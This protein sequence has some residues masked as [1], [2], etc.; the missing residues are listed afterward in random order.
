MAYHWY[1]IREIISKG[2]I[3]VPFPCGTSTNHHT[4]FVFTTIPWCRVSV[5]WQIENS[6]NR[7]TTNGGFQIEVCSHPVKDHL[8]GES[9]YSPWTKSLRTWAPGV[10]KL[11]QPQRV[12]P[13]FMVTRQCRASRH[14]VWVTAVLKTGA[15]KGRKIHFSGVSSSLSGRQYLPW[16]LHHGDFCFYLVGQN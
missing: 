14:L 7:K 11:L 3:W 6:T 13:M 15:G 10:S 8:E 5:W 12:A 2:T 4:E 1:R 9:G 16:K